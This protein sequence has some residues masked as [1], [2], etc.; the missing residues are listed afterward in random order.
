MSTAAKPAEIELAELSQEE[1]RELIR[2]EAQHLNMTLEEAVK[3]AKSGDLPRNSWGA[4]V[5]LLVG[6]LQP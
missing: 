4:D 2:N 6:L 1:L 3:A 5:E